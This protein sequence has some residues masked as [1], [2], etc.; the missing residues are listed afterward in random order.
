MSAKNAIVATY[1][2]RGLAEADLRNLLAAGFDT[3]KLSIAGKEVQGVAGGPEPV[4]EFREVDPQTYNCIPNEDASA[5]EAE[6]NA[7][8]VILVAHGTADEIARAKGIIEALHPISW[9]ESA[10]SA[11]YYGCAD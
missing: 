11:V 9:D 7:G 3:G 4:H 10:D 1:A 2:N 8:R 6:L 5:Y